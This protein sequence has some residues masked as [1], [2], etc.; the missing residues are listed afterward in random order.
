MQVEVPMLLLTRHSYEPLLVG[1]SLNL[2][3][4]VSFRS[5][6][7]IRMKSPLRNQRMSV[8]RGGLERSTA[9]L[10]VTVW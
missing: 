8:R 6:M 5:G 7:G 1:S 4:G 9:H 3:S 2:S 10:R